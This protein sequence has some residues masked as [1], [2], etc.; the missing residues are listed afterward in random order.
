MASLLRVLEEH[1]VPD[2]AAKALLIVVIF[3]AAWV[4][5]RLASMV[6]R[7]LESR[8]SDDDD[9]DV[10]P[11]VALSRQ[12]T[13]VSLIST[14]IRYVVYLVACGLSV[15]VLLGGRSVGTVAGASFVA[16]LIGFAAQRFLIDIMA[17]FLMFFEHWFTIGTLVVIEPW[18]LEGVVEEMSLRAT[19]I[20]D[21]NGDLMH[22]HNSQILAVRVLPDG[23]RRVD[24]EL[25]V[26]DRDAGERLVTEVGALV[27]V[28]PTAF[29]EAP[30]IRAAEQL[31]GDLWRI[32]AGAAVAGG[33]LWLAEELLPSL[34]KERAGEGLIVHGP[35]ILPTADAAVNRFRRAERQGRRATAGAT[36]RRPG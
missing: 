35:V 6:A 24:I 36:R 2:A 15:I 30:T 19:T 33:R 31:D 25:F 21:A 18:K 16:V 28:G 1:G 10:S 13:A 12:E 23:V 26:R 27:P 3:T 8:A 34:L 32:T 4:V 22:V 9:E 7:A 11:L 29:I 17:G 5:A 14:T 20:R